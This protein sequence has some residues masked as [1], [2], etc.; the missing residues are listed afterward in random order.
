M[1][2]KR[3]KEDRS[4]YG[5]LKSVDRDAGIGVVRWFQTFKPDLETEASFSGER[6]EALY[7]L[8]IHPTF[9]LG[10]IEHSYYG[11]SGQHFVEVGRE[12]R[13]EIRHGQIVASSMGDGKVY[14]SWNDGTVGKA[15]PQQLF[16]VDRRLADTFASMSSKTKPHKCLRSLLIFFS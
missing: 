3:N 9:K 6:D 11:F 7:D 14:V 10:G 16:K 1:I 4:K 13:N 12:D 2:S 15:W 5:F 8:A